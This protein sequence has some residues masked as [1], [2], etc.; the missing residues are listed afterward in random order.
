MYM[1][2]CGSDAPFLI[3]AETGESIK[4]IPPQLQFGNGV[5]LSIRS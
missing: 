1:Y 2:D 3:K 5:N 4:R